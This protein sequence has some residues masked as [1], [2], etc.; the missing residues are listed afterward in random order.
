MK[1]CITTKQYEELSHEAK[2]IYKSWMTSHG[3][4]GNKATEN[5]INI[6]QMIEF[7]TEHVKGKR[8][9]IDL[10]QVGDK[11]LWGMLWH[12]EQVKEE[13]VEVLWEAVKEILNA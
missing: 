6:G 10:N 3:Y 8:E 11:H 5:A 13:L 4:F 7:I 2:E 12:P 1:Q 9:G